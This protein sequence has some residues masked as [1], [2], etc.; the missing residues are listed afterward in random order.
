MKLPGHYV[1]VVNEATGLIDVF[2]ARK[3]NSFELS[4]N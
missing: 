2:I 3:E 4:N 1:A